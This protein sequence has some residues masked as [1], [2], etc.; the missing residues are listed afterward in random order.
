VFLTL[1]HA[2]FVGFT[3]VFV[4]LAVLH[5]PLLRRVLVAFAA[6][7]SLL[8]R[9]AVTRPPVAMLFR[10]ALLALLTARISALPS[11]RLIL[12][13]ML[14]GA[15]FRIFVSRLVGLF[16]ARLF[17]RRS[18]A[19]LIFVVL[20]RLISFPS[21]IFLLSGLMT[22]LGTRILTLMLSLFL[23]L[24]STHL[25]SPFVCMASSDKSM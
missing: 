20:I 6:I 10:A 16:P 2:A 4:A 5:I 15:T 9:A 14:P 17:Y 1:L 21:V 7:A 12:A 25:Y 24:C 11:L 18:A 19:A 13:A 23:R 8:R 22:T 3:G